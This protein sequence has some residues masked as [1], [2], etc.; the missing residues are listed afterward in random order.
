[1]GLNH[2]STSRIR[3]L[4]LQIGKQPVGAHLF[5]SSLRAFHCP[6]V[7][8]V[9]S[10]FFLLNPKQGLVGVGQAHTPEV[11]HRVRFNPN[12][13]VQDPVL[14]VLQ[15]LPDPVDVVVRTDHPQRPGRFE[16]P[17][18][19]GQPFAGEVVILGKTIELIPVVVHSV[20]L[21]QVGAP[22]FALQL[23]V[24]GRVGEDQVNRIFRQVGQNLAAVAD[25]YLVQWEVCGRLWP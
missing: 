5:R 23:E 12:H 20:H 25:E 9:F 14:E 21:G 16:H 18:A 11:R 15:D 1:M 4:P 19:G 6:V 8:G 22:E 24:I 13:I 7:E 3:S 2:H 10:A 17:P